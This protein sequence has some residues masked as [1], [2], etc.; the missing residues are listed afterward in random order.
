MTRLKKEINFKRTFK[1]TCDMKEQYIKLFYAI[2]TAVRSFKF[3]VISFFCRKNWIVNFCTFAASFI[4]CCHEVTIL[5][6]KSDEM[7][8]IKDLF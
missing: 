6:K 1:L 2:E 5:I 7:I 4:D 8:F 3:C